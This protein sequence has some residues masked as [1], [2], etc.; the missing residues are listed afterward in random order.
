MGTSNAPI[1]ALFDRGLLVEDLNLSTVITIAPSVGI[2]LDG[3]GACREAIEANV[4]PGGTPS[5][6][7]RGGGSKI[8]HVGL[9]PQF[10]I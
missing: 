4:S 3:L 6:Y 5:V 9:G 1:G 7:R 2:I 8:R 10:S